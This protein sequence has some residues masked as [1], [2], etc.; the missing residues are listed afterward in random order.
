M[1]QIALLRRL[2]HQQ[3]VTIGS[4]VDNLFG[5]VAGQS[6]AILA[7]Q[8]QTWMVVQIPGTRL[9]SPDEFYAA[10]VAA[11]TRQFKVLQGREGV[12]V[13]ESFRKNAGV[14]SS[15]LFRTVV[16][17]PGPI[18]MA[19]SI[20][21]DSSAGQMGVY[22][23]GVL[24]RKGNGS[25]SLP[26]SLSAG[27]HLI[28]ITAVALVVGLAA[29]SSLRLFFDLELV[30]VPQWSAIRTGFFDATL[31]V[32]GVQLEWF[33]DNRVGG[34]IVFRRSITYLN[35]ITS[36]GTV[37]ANN[38]FQLDITGNVVSQVLVGGSILAGNEPMGTVSSCQYD[39]DNDVTTVRVQL[40]GTRDRT[41]L[42]WIGRKAAVGQFTEQ[43]RI[44]R[45]TRTGPV[46][47]TDT[48]V[49]LNQVYEYALQAFGLFDESQL[50]A[51]SE[52][53]RVVAG[54]SVAPASIV[55]TIG[56]PSVSF[57][58]VTVKF[59]TPPDE[60]YE[61]V[62]VLYYDKPLDGFGTSTGGNTATTLVAGNKLWQANAFVGYFVAITGGTGI[63]QVGTILSN[64]PTSMTLTPESAWTVTP[65]STSSFE[66]YKLTGVIT[67]YGL[68]NTADELRFASLG[69]GVYYFCAFDKAGNTQSIYQ[70]AQWEFVSTLSAETP[71]TNALVFDRSPAGKQ[72]QTVMGITLYSI[73]PAEELVLDTFEAP[74]GTSV[75]RLDIGTFVS[76]G[77]TTLTAQ[78]PSK[79]WVVNAFANKELRIYSQ[80]ADYHYKVRI[81]SNTATVL[82]LQA[83]LPLPPNGMNYEIYDHVPNRTLGS[84][85]GW[86]SSDLSLAAIYS[87]ELRY[88][89]VAGGGTQEGGS[90]NIVYDNVNY[91][92]KPSGLLTLTER[93]FDAAVE[94][95]WSASLLS[96]PIVK[97]LGAPMS[98]DN[99]FRWTWASGTTQNNTSPG[100]NLSRDIPPVTSLY[101]A[102]WIR[103]GPDWYNNS[104][105]QLNL[106]GIWTDFL[107]GGELMTL[108]LAGSGVGPYTPQL[109]RSAY[110]VGFIAV[111]EE[112]YPPNASVVAINR[113][114][115]YKYE[116]YLRW[117]TPG[118]SDGIMQLWVNNTPVYSNSTLMFDSWN[119]TPGQLHWTKLKIRPTWGI[120]AGLDETTQDITMYMDHYFAAGL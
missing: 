9:L 105:N 7:E 29:P 55:F 62:R 89:G 85:D 11:D 39:T 14:P 110:T 21:T 33:S 116:W 47:W 76:F 60:D 15:F 104:E 50:S 69:N 25:M 93:R 6:P 31:G 75:K 5:A 64:G 106:L 24:I 108:R 51:L 2:V 95:S 114:V 71:Q 74:S 3:L 13:S 109:H 49:Q 18:V 91:T 66:I 42:D 10:Y 28:E 118:N 88:T 17:Q 12:L 34:W 117:N 80:G 97:D 27:R 90:D 101:V 81:A 65:D 23:D 26:L 4:P 36:V 120:S 45:T 53:R 35:L 16:D 100:N 67:D 46:V 54:D 37:N 87:N 32:L 22:V 41:E 56:Y 115:W 96:A 99:V 58:I 70:S 52:I 107:G 63:G 94:D 59:T 102:S 92:N 82:T 77:N 103:L 68:P 1:S 30:P 86:S 73:P 113:G 57:N 78:D 79:A 48:N 83:D 8:E 40:I 84:R 61:G 112:Y 20:E 38:E 44:R 111:P 72:S 119:D 43:A 98:P 19:L